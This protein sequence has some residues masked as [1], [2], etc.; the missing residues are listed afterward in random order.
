MKIL[1]IES[2]ATACSVAL[3]EGPDLIAQSIQNS[4]LTHSTTLLPMVNSLLQNC[5]VTL[6][7]VDVFATSIGPG[8]FTG[9]RIGV[10][11][12]KG[13]AWAQDKPCVSCSTLEAMAWPLA[14]LSQYQ[15]ICAMDT[16]RNQI[17]N[18][19]FVI[20]DGRPVRLVD[21]HAIAAQA[22]ALELRGVS[23]PKI[24]VGDGAQL[25]Y[26]ILK[27]SGVDAQRA[28]E[29]LRMQSAWGV[30]LAVQAKIQSRDLVSAGDLV[31]VYL[32]PSQAERERLA[33]QTKEQQIKG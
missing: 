27:E 17:Y 11:T 24:V 20:E 19:R 23:G 9:L 7:D 22:L 1:A 2:S 3:S 25:C 13:L 4:G 8:S 28:P 32:R 10:S 5:G 21:D 18:S 33:R 31:P 14:H 15:V 30:I 12:V 29:H 26:N 6:A 16:R